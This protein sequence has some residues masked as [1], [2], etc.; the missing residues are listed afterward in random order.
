VPRVHETLVID[1]EKTAGKTGRHP[2][3]ILTLVQ[4]AAVLQFFTRLTS[5]PLQGPTP[6]WPLPRIIGRLDDRMRKAVIGQFNELVKLRCTGLGAQGPGKDSIHGCGSHSGQQVPPAEFLSYAGWPLRGV[7]HQFVFGFIGELSC[8]G[9]QCI[10]LPGAFLRN[11]EVIG[12]GKKIKMYTL[13]VGMLRFEL[14]E[15]CAINVTTAGGLSMQP[16]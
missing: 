2:A 7:V 1:H 10:G 14:G 8:I 6:G 9:G 11:Q 13:W 3:K 4:G 5:K 16:E 12:H 15:T